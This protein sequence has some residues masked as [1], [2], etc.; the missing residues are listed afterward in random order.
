MY[1]NPE[2]ESDKGDNFTVPDTEIPECP[3]SFV[4]PRSRE[5]VQIFNRAQ[6][7]QGAGASMFGPDLSKWPIWA[8]D[9]QVVLEQARI[10]EHNARFEAE[11]EP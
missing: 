3:V 11:R 5:L 2:Y 6:Y 10:R 8:V 1:H 4:T 7:S 9:A